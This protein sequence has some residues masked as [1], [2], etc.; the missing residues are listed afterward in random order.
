MLKIGLIGLIFLSAHVEAAVPRKLYYTD[1]EQILLSKNK[2]IQI[3]KIQ[4]EQQEYALKSS[5]SGFLPT[6]T[7]DNFYSDKIDSTESTSRKIYNN[8][9][10]LSQNVFSGF[11]DYYKVKNSKLDLLQSNNNLTLEKLKQRAELKMA[12]ANVV[13]TQRLLKFSEK[14]INTRKDIRELVSLRFTSGN[15]TQDS[16]LFAEGQLDESTLDLDNSRRA[17]QAAK[18]RLKFI[19]GEDLQ[20][21]FEVVGSIPLIEIPTDPDFQKLAVESLEFKNAAINERK[22]IEDLSSNRAKYLPTVDVSVTREG[23]KRRNFSRNDFNKIYATTY[24]VNVSFPIFE[25]FSTYHDVKVSELEQEKNRINLT[26]VSEDYYNTL[27]ETYDRLTELKKTKE[28]YLK[29]LEAAKLRDMI[30]TSK[31]RLGIVSF[32]VWIDSQNDL[33]NYEKNV[34]QIDYEIEANLSKWETLANARAQGI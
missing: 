27:R 2:D 26:K 14:T 4:V 3:A 20:D 17:L 10:T 18:R 33:I 5:Y 19:L 16:I 7:Y 15:E 9:I 23:D 1:V 31:Y 13:L 30:H 29:L 32:E 22:S 34:I 8:S 28:V 25:G 24:E 6:L 12:F 21:D 11:Q